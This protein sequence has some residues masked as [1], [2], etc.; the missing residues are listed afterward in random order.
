M[1]RLKRKGRIS[2]PRTALWAL[3]GRESLTFPFKGGM[4]Y[5]ILPCITGQ[6]CDFITL[7]PAKRRSDTTLQRKHASKHYANVVIL[8]HQLQMLHCDFSTYQNNSIASKVITISLVT[9]TASV[10]QF[11]GGSTRSRHKKGL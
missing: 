2:Q 5:N 1:S 9:S 6:A 10:P 8:V 4:T 3:R 11:H 7:S